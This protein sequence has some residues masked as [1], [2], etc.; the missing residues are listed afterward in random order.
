MKNNLFIS[1][2]VLLT[3][4]SCNKDD[5]AFDNY[6]Q[7]PES[8]NVESFCA[9][10]DSL[11]NAYSEMLNAN[12]T[13]G[14][15]SDYAIT[16]SADAVGAFVGAKIFSWVGSAIGAACANPALACGGYF[17]GKKFGDAAGSAVASIGAAWLIDKLGTRSSV[18]SSLVL[19]KD[20]VV[21]VEDPNNLT[22]GELHN[23]ILAELL[24]NIDKYVMPNGSLNYELLL[25]DAYMYENQF[26]PFEEYPGYKELWLPK[27]IEQTRRIVDASVALESNNISLFLDEVYNGLIPELQIT[28]EEFENANILNEKALSTYTMLDN[29]TLKEFSKDIDDVIESSNLNDDLKD[30]LK[31]SNSVM[32]NSTLI[33]REVQ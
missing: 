8:Q 14:Y 33:W 7:I 18:N 19:N 1:V 5:V 29:V 22:D 6:A 16:T 27:A 17:I 23:L 32:T 31:V 10:I 21:P 12:A 25:S 3:L 13:R 26:A 2:V 24:K 30:E 15:V 20:Y 9:K 28:K 11:N 4:I